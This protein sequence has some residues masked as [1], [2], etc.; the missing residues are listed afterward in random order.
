MTKKQKPLGLSADSL[1]FFGL[2]AVIILCFLFFVPKVAS[3]LFP[4]KRQML[5]HNFMG[6]VQK[7]KT[8]DP[9]TF[10]EF[11][12]FYSPGYYTVNKT[13]LSQNQIQIAEKSIGIFLTK[14]P[15]TNIF[16]SF[17]SPHLHSMEALVTTSS[18]GNVVNDQTIEK[19][20][21]LLAGNNET[22]FT[23][24]KGDTYILFLKPVSDMQTANGYF[25][26]KDVD[27]NIVQG[28][29]WL[30]ITKLDGK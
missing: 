14:Q 17:T 9:Q 12:E 22:V 27:K 23:D 21:V 24:A 10:W 26:Y 4:F 6:V 19:A 20:K 18:L 3:A 2:F 13:G 30:D 25:D 28:K 16:L 29:Y 8:V 15:N 1:T 5:L 7:E 11:R